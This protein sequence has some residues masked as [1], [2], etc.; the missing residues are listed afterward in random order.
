MIIDDLLATGGTVAASRS[1]IERLGGHVVAA[2]FVVEL[3]FLHGRDRLQGLDIF[4]L[5]K[6]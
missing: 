2:G 6:Y 5:L 4:S 1:L 3:E